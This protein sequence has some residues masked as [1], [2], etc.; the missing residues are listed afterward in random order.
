MGDFVDIKNTLLERIK[1]ANEDKKPL[2]IRAANTKSFL[3]HV[4]ESEVID[5]SNY[6]GIV[7]YEPS[8]L[9]ITVRAGTSLKEIESTLAD[10][11]Q[12][13]AFEPPDFQNKSTIGGTIA[14]GLS[15]PRRPYTGSARDFVLGVECI[16]GRGELL[17]FGG[18]VI[19]NVAG[20]DVSRLMTGAFGT[21]AALLEI[22]LK[23]VPKPEYEVAY[24]IATD[25]KTALRKVHEWATQPLPLSASCYESGLLKLRL[26]GKESTLEKARQTMALLKRDQQDVS[27][28]QKLKDLE[29][30][31][32]RMDKTPL[33]RL[34]VPSNTPD[35]NLKGDCLI[36]W[37]GALRWLKSNE[38]A[39]HVRDVV[40]QYG[41]HAT[42]YFSDDT[43]IE[44]FHPL[45]QT[46]KVIHQNLK[47][48]FDPNR[49]LN[50]GRMYKDI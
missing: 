11:G 23:V 33:W 5:L 29:L 32:F 31:F 7:S 30:A 41:G 35:L 8:E 40:S 36:D 27:Y 42:L 26:S 39:E 16:N 34:S 2:T 9:Y 28:F 1:Q 3:G 37:G 14:A 10:S 20:Y 44:R 6:S 22:S 45:N 38:E 43:S 17:G 4:V 19:K 18:Q 12:M 50:R 15:G 13:L 49:I 47:K 24:S 21:L 25:F 48:A 46:V